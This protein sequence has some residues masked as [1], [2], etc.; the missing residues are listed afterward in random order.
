MSRYILRNDIL[1]QTYDIFSKAIDKIA[2]FSK[3]LS[4]SFLT[5]N[6]SVIVGLIFKLFLQLKEVNPLGRDGPGLLSL[7]AACIWSQI[8]TS[9]PAPS[10]LWSHMCNDAQRS[11]H[12]RMLRCT[13]G[14]CGPRRAGSLLV[15]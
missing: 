3:L 12:V 10:V 4:G 7:L 6:T 14:T 15:R 2:Q 9:C 11:G 5:I 1:D 13:Y 8:C